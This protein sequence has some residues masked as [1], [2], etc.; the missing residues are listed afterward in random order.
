MPFLFVGSGI[1]RRYLGL[2][3]WED[4]LRKYSVVAGRPYEYY[5][6]SANGDLPGIAAAIAADLHDRWWSEES[7]AES[8]AEFANDAIRRESALKIEIAR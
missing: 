8:R 6:S 4:L 5:R 7:F 2:E 1:S 3:N